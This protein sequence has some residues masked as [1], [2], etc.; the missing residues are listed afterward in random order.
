MK[1]RDFDIDTALARIETAVRPWPKAAL[2]Q[3]AEEGYGSVFEQLMACI[4]SIRTFDEVTL[5]ASRRLFERARTPTALARLTDEEVDALINPSTFHER[6]AQQMREIARRV[7]QDHGGAL[8]ADRDV[9]LSFAGV[10][11]KC[12]NLVLGVACGEP[13]I[14]VDVHVHRVTGRW[15][16]VHAS[17]PERALSALEAKLPRRHWIDINRLLVPFGKHICT[18]R[19]PHCSTCPVLDMC[20]QVGVSGHR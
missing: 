8:P 19:L 12:A 14:S 5:P 10:G 3:L 4:I 18:G 20:E 1:T 11:P 13:I 15:G 7:E 16:Y 6:K 17:S 9:L 2:F